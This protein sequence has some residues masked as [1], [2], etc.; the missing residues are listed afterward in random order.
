MDGIAF[1]RQDTH[2]TLRFASA[3]C[4]IGHGA[5]GII[6][7]SAWLNYFAVFG[8]GSAAGYH[9]MPW[10][11]TVDILIGLSILIYPIPV[12]LLWLV[13]WGAATALLRPLSGE[14][15]AEAIERAGNYGAPLAL[16]I[17]S[18][19]RT[20]NKGWFLLIDPNV[21]LNQQT[22]V[23]AK[24][25]LRIVVFLLLTGHGW[26]NLIEKKGLIDQYSSAGFSNP[27]LVAQ[28]AGIF[29]IGA[30]V[31]I[32][33][34]PIRAIIMLLL[35]WKMV[36][37]LFYPHW[38]VFEW[39]ERA[40]SYGSLLAFWL[41]LNPDSIRSKKS[42]LMT[43]IATGIAGLFVLSLYYIGSSGASSSRLTPIDTTALNQVIGIDKGIHGATFVFVNEIPGTTTMHNRIIQLPPIS[44]ELRINFDRYVHPGHFG[45]LFIV[46]PDNYAGP[47]EKFILRSF[48]GYKGWYGSMLSRNF[49]MYAAK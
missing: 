5:F 38:E 44:N 40:G 29:E 13:V 19:Q 9:L 6:T 22:L 1:P 36:T 37:E 27:S 39:I 23:K 47:K 7:K 41:L 14:P 26:L 11:G 17:L 34:K 32:L 24:A 8:I 30:G 12:S 31:M 45:P 25:I 4:F 21:T 43:G 35:V 3:M 10:L 49:V 2:Y 33:I 42:L 20:R 16:L 18:G 46:L 15:F 28:I 48:P